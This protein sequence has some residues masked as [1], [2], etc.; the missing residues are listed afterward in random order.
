MKIWES[1][2]GDEIDWR[3]TVLHE[4]RNL[5][6]RFWCSICV[7][8]RTEIFDHVLMKFCIWKVFHSP[9]WIITDFSLGRTGKCFSQNFDV[10]RLNIILHSYNVNTRRN[11]ALLQDVDIV[12]DIFTGGRKITILLTLDT[13]IEFVCRYCTILRAPCG[14]IL[15]HFLRRAIILIPYD[16]YCEAA[17]R[18]WVRLRTIFVRT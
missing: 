15:Q 18:F 4:T 9:I 13:P 6:S 2:S 16:V 3:L 1:G 7:L 10:N 12:Y 17:Q 8:N 5:R 11:N 14:N